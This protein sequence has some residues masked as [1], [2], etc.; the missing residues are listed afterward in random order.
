MEQVLLK[1]LNLLKI[2]LPVC[3]IIA[4]TRTNTGGV[5]FL[6]KFKEQF[7]ILTA[8]HVLDKDYILLKPKDE[9]YKKELLTS[10]IDNAAIQFYNKTLSDLQSPDYLRN[11]VDYSRKCLM[12]KKSNYQNGTQINDDWFDFIFI[13]I[14][15]DYNYP[16]EF[17]DS[18]LPLSRNI[19]SNYAVI[20]FYSLAVNQGK[21][22]GF[23]IGTLS[24]FYYTPENRPVYFDYGSNK[25]IDFSITTVGGASGSPL[26]QL[27]SNDEFSVIGLHF[28]YDDIQGTG[29]QAIPIDFIYNSLEHPYEVQVE[30]LLPLQSPISQTSHP[31]REVYWDLNQTI[32]KKI[33]LTK[34]AKAC[35]RAICLM[36]YE[37]ENGSFDLGCGLVIK[38]EKQNLGVVTLTARVCSESECLLPL[39]YILIAFWNEEGYLG[40]FANVKEYTNDSTFMNYCGFSVIR[41]LSQEQ[42]SQR[43]VNMIEV[44]RNSYELMWKN[45]DSRAIEF[46][47]A[48]PNS[49]ALLITARDSPHNY[50]L[51]LGTIC[52][53][54]FEASTHNI[55]ELNQIHRDQVVTRIVRSNH[56]EQSKLGGAVF[57]MRNNQIVVVGLVQSNLLIA[58]L[59]LVEM[60]FEQP[61]IGSRMIITRRIANF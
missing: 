15:S 36:R 22:S 57:Q 42:L 54:D 50:F 14:R 29:N 44:Q 23:N 28:G 38:T 19:N 58:D 55:Y 48:N 11:I 27:Q 8:L 53:L 21:T 45:I 7:G 46:K 24:P 43:T 33:W 10:W 47:S 25:L 41:F 40:E 52:L 17:F 5:G 37:I 4:D 9:S 1:Q 6:T 32:I 60:A 30:L 35:S 13:P 49:S 51:Y 20:I 59:A 12:H 2:L 39:S 61:S 3:R 16:N 31:T 56:S 26:I 18:F 34:D